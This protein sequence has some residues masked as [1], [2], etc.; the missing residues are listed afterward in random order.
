MGAGTYL[1]IPALR[2]AHKWS[3]KQV[4]SASSSPPQ[5][6]Q[7][8]VCAALLRASQSAQSVGPVSR[9]S[10]SPPASSRRP[11]ARGDDSE[12]K[13]LSAL[14]YALQSGQIMN[15]NMRGNHT[16]TSCLSQHSQEVMSPAIDLWHDAQDR[17]HAWLALTSMLVKAALAS[18][19]ADQDSQQSLT[20]WP[21]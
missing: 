5:G 20:R 4:C 15:K 11:L 1:S 21:T 6:P 8:V 12:R 7:S 2:P 3:T 10:Q 14:F 13:R 18:L 16:V 17:G 19:S 9:P